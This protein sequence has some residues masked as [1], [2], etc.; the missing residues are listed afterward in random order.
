MLT[1][2]DLHGCISTPLWF[3]NNINNTPMAIINI[4][5]RI[6]LI[7]TTAGQKNAKTP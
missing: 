1:L 6:N 5:K 7:L 3:A 2:L 4:L